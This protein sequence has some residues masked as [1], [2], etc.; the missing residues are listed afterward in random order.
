MGRVRDQIYARW[1]LR[2]LFYAFLAAAIFVTWLVLDGAE[3][4]FVYSEF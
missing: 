2:A 3:V 1:Y 4:A